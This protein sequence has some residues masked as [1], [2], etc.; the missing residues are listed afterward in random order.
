[1]LRVNLAHRKFPRPPVVY[2]QTRLLKDGGVTTATDTHTYAKFILP[3]ESSAMLE[4]VYADLR[5]LRAHDAKSLSIEGH[6]VVHWT[7]SARAALE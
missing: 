6:C 4:Y 1:M 2:Q 5:L 7:W 3:S